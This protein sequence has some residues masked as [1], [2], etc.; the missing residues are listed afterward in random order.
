MPRILREKDDSAWFG[1]LCPPM[2][3]L[4]SH[5]RHMVFAVLH[6]WRCVSS[7]RLLALIRVRTNEARPST[8]LSC[9]RLHLC[10]ELFCFFFCLTCFSTNLLYLFSV[11]ST[12]SPYPI[13]FHPIPS[14]RFVTIGSI[15]HTYLPTCRTKETRRTCMRRVKEKKE[16]DPK[17]E[18]GTPATPITPS[19]PPPPPPRRIHAR[20]MAHA[21][22][23][24]HLAC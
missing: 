7:S 22:P 11:F 2:L 9:P 14:R 12:A 8:F 3:H 15:L 16:A 18:N 13:P 23:N 4:F 5:H 17:G 24:S 1:L 19:L 6:H 21:L 10:S 20:T